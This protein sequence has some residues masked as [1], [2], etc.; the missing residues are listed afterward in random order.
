MKKLM[1]LALVASLCMTQTAFAQ[2]EGDAAVAEAGTSSSYSVTVAERPLTITGGSLNADA[3]LLF[4]GGFTMDILEIGASYGIM[5]DF[6]VG[7]SLPLTVGLLDVPA[8][9][10]DMTV[11]AVY[12]FMDGDFEMGAALDIHIP[13]NTNFGLSVGAPLQYRA[14]MMRLRSGVMLNMEFADAMVLGAEIPVG[15]DLALTESF[16]VG[17]NTGFNIASFD[18]F[19]W[20]LPLGVDVGYTF[21]SGSPVAD[22]SVRFAMPNFASDAGLDAGNYTVG[23]MSR[24]YIL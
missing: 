3:N 5:D 6:E 24:I 19:A 15:V 20:A 8:T 21:G 14:G 23:L 1:T 13:L 12:R 4:A 9:A 17:V 16:N 7:L 2:E 22:L 11:G 10:G 18:G